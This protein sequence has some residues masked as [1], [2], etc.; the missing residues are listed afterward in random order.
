LSGY[1]LAIGLNVHSPSLCFESHR[2]NISL[3]IMPILHRS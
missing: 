2:H 3:L 1:V